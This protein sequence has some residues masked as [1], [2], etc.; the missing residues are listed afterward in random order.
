M[1]SIQPELQMNDDGHI[2]KRPANFCAVHGIHKKRA[3]DNMKW[4]KRSNSS[5]IVPSWM[6]YQE[7]IEPDQ[8][9]SKQRCIWEKDRMMII[10]N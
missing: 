1:N 7:W 5:S 3:K 9:I 2:S 10:G 4:R 6:K 8:S